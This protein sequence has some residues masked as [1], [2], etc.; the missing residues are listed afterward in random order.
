MSSS[1]LRVKCEA[2]TSPNNI[3]PVE[4]LDETR[5]TD[6]DSGSFTGFRQ[7]ASS[8]VPYGVIILNYYAFGLT[9]AAERQCAAIS[10]DQGAPVHQYQTARISRAHVPSLPLC[11]F[12]VI[13]SAEPGIKPTEV[14]RE[15]RRTPGRN[16]IASPPPPCQFPA[17][18]PTKAAVS[19][20]QTPTRST[21][22][23]T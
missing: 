3:S 8:F 14:S 16:R 9:L 17:P 4:R 21:Q 5:D 12:G 7:A 2:H 20:T 22:R 13:H 6:E 15:P 19:P 11:G 1:L 18:A 10:N 23:I